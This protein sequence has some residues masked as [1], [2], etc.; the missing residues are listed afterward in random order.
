MIAHPRAYLDQ[1][2]PAQVEGVYRASLGIL[3][4]T[5]LAVQ[6]ADAV[7]ILA[8]AGAHVDGGR[9]RFPHDILERLVALSPRRFTLHAR[10]PARSVEV[11]GAG[12]AVSPGYGS[13]SVADVRG[14][15]RDA[16]LADF[17]RFAGLAAACDAIDITGGLL[18]EPLDVPAALRPLEISRSLIER[19]DKPFLGSVAGAAGA[20]ESLDL[21]RIVFGGSDTPAGQG[22]D[23]GGRAVM[24]ALVNINSPLRLDERMAEALLAYARAGQAVLLTPGILMGV[25]AP[26][27]AV[28]A[29]A[30][31]MAELLACTALVQVVRPGSPV[32]IGTGGFGS[33][34]RTGGP[35]FG[36]PENALGSVLGAELARRIGLPF[37][38]SGMV[39]GSRAPDCRSGYERMMTA[40]AAWT[41]GAHVC[42]QGAGTLDSINSMSYEQFTIDAEIW[43]YLKRL[44]AR[45]AVDAGTLAVDV[46]ASLPVDYLGADHAME[47]LAAEMAAV[48]LATPK[49]YD[50]WLAEGALDVVSLAG[51]RL[52]KLETAGSVQPLGDGIRRELARYVRDRR[53]AL[54]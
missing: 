5:G 54:G 22:G 7:R 52:E 21:A 39:T 43:A 47:H 29:L 4:Q 32:V 37:R 51:K 23:F 9:V 49:S 19:S 10:N 17:E 11:G 15:S 26:V 35:G 40:M 28:G 34:L 14:R 18:V 25:T 1:L 2:D 24:M 42:L 16:T 20:R 48:S 12:L 31:A 38:C 30:Q 36:R 46:I 33:D 13:P 41:A 44:A 45:P 53:R 50:E 8:D 27:T 6:S 3:E